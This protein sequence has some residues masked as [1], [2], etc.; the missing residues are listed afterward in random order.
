M[1]HIDSSHF[2][3]KKRRIRI[4]NPTANASENEA[5][6]DEA[7]K[8]ARLIPDAPDP[9]LGR[10]REI[11]DEI[12]KGIYFQPHMIDETAARL[13]ARLLKGE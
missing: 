6:W 11:K 13:A 9:H 8:F 7:R 4:Q 12:R 10:V 1:D 5:L 3:E 2:Q